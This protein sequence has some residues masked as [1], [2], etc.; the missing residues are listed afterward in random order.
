MKNLHKIII[1]IVAILF[2]SGC[3]ATDL[4][5][6]V[7]PE[8]KLTKPIVASNIFDMPKDASR[9]VLAISARLLDSNKKIK[10]VTVQP[11]NQTNLIDNRLFN[12]QNSILL[13]YKDGNFADQKSLKADAFFI[14]SL[15]RSLAFTINATYTTQS[16]QI[17]VQN[18]T[19][20]NKYTP[21]K[22]TVCF[23]VPA[24]K[25]LKFNKQ[26]IPRTFYDLYQYAALNSV[27]PDQTSNYGKNTQWATM[28]F[29]LDRM[30]KSAVS[31]LGVS[32]KVSK[33]DKGITKNTKFINY[34][35][36]RVG[37]VVGKFHL[38]QPN[39]THPLYVK[40][41]YTPG[42]EY[43]GNFL[44]KNAELLGMYRIK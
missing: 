23:I 13:S 24:N 10:D 11:L 21:A 19:V 33:Y 39:F 36:W 27:T 37:I 32:D 18:Y 41:F 3:V 44:S 8:K 22:N 29:F 42:K 16:N 43:K 4:K 25:Y 35:G 6:N 20:L 38:L 30:S 7:F 17:I 5:L 15:G 26:N 2:F 31:E 14:D 34:N 9:V 1:L 40:A 28:V 12:F